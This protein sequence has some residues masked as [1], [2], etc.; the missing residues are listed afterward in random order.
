M[1]R[2]GIAA[3]KIAKGSLFFYNLYVILIAILVSL[4]LYFIAGSSI[5]LGLI[6]VGYIVKGVLPGQMEQDWLAIVRVCM[7][8]LTVVV[9]AVSIFAI[10]VNIKFSK[11]K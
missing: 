1:K 6:V 7:V 10:L 3:S 8:S 9:S 2:I 11:E 5:V 4:F